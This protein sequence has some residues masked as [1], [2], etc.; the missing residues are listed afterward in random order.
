MSTMQ[1]VSEEVPGWW[2]IML[3]VVVVVVVIG[4]LRLD[5]RKLF[6]RALFRTLHTLDGSGES[7]T[8]CP[9]EWMDD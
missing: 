4:P 1:S 3:V 2:W 9:L 8:A 5:W 6:A 7:E